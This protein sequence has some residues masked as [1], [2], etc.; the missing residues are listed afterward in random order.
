MLPSPILAT[1]TAPT[2]AAP[3]QREECT[4]FDLIDIANRM[5]K[6]NRSP[7]FDDCLMSHAAV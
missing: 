1:K 7:F 2:Y 4:H 3:G 6:L 5:V